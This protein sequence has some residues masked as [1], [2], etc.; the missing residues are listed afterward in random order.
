MAQTIRLR[1]KTG[2]AGAPTSAQIQLGEPA[3]NTFTGK[4]YL[5]DDDN[6]IVDMV[7]DIIDVTVVSGVLQR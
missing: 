2:S 4:I 7:S 6:V 5:K 3:V 1:R